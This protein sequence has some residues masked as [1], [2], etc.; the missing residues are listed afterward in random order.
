[1]MDFYELFGFAMGDGH[2]F[3]NHKYRK[4]R[5]ELVG[6]V[7]G[8]YDYFEQL[9]SFLEKVSS[10]KPQLFIYK[11]KRGKILKLMI[12]DKAFVD[13]LIETGLPAGKKTFIVKIPN[14]INA[15]QQTAILRGLL[16]VDGCLYF[17]KS[18]KCKYPTYTRLGIK[19]SSLVLFTQLKVILK[20]RGFSP[21]IRNPSTDRTFA[22]EISGE[23]ALKKWIREIGFSGLKNR[24]KYLFWKAKGFYMPRTPL[25]KRL[26]YAHVA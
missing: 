7:E 5:L 11:N 13:K 1:M 14:G 23:E 24:T 25:K 2:I 22:V 18:K 17:S 20:D 16:E 19:T 15:E 26:K 6:N 4:Y 10:K 8:D 12:Y 3:Y 21:Y 9:K